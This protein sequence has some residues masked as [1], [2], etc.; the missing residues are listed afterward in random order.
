MSIKISARPVVQDDWTAVPNDL[1]QLA[2]T[3]A[4]RRHAAEAIVPVMAM[5]EAPAA[6]GLEPVPTIRRDFPTE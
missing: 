1:R 6:S 5:L 3:L 4:W 2:A